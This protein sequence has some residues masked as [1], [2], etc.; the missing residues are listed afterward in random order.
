MINL[1]EVKNL[2]E[3]DHMVIEA[4]K[5]HALMLCVKVSASGMTRNYK[6]MTVFNDHNGQSIVDCGYTLKK[7]GYT[8]NKDFLVRIQGWG[9]SPICD[10]AHD[11][12]VPQSTIKEEY[13]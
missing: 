8:T 2:T 7:L 1:T 5:K 11:L 10:L 12:G 6:V 4:M 3:Y 13:I 9:F